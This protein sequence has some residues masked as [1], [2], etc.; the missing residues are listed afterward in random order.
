MCFKDRKIFTYLK[1]RNKDNLEEGKELIQVF[2]SSF[3]YREKKRLRNDF[4][5]TLVPTLLSFS[6]AGIYAI[7]DGFFVGNSL[8]DKGLAAINFAYPFLAL[9]QAL[10]TG[11]GLACAVYYVD[12]KARNKYQ[13]A[14][15]CVFLLLILNLLFALFYLLVAYPHQIFILKLFGASF[16][17]LNLA[18]SYVRIILLGGIFQLLANSLL[19]L[20]RAEGRNF[21][22]AFSMI[23]GFV[24]NL[25]LDYHY[26]FQLKRGIAGAALASV[27]AQA[28]SFLACVFGTLLYKLYSKFSLSPFL[29]VVLLKKR[30]SNVGFCINSK[31]K[32]FY[33]Q[34]SFYQN[35]PYLKMSMGIVSLAFAPIGIELSPNLLLILSN[36]QAEMFG[37]TEAVAAYTII[38]YM[39]F[40]ILLMLQAVCSASQSHLSYYFS[41]KEN[42]HLKQIKK[43]MHLSANFIVLSLLL[44]FV[45][46]MKTLARLYGSSPK[47]E[48]LL[49]QALP[50]F[51]SGLI[52][53]LYLRTQSTYAYSIQNRLEANFI[54]YG[55]IF[56]AFIALLVLPIFLGLQGVWLAPLLAQILIFS[57]Y[58]I[59]Y[60]KPKFFFSR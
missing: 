56:F 20:L 6:L 33:H 15:M 5:R 4:L 48:S 43:W 55:E 58:L 35:F 42:L 1:S 14:R 39:T 45:S 32:I 16:E 19:P 2:S 53:L 22:A 26:V 24:V 17:V 52:I 25:Y 21:L 10:G 34:L 8:G 11:L 13:E 51:I 49:F 23:L 7:V 36:K 60:I 47:A 28:L 27:T 31:R 30:L 59:F 57:L 29:Q 54:I 44:L 18:Q 3:S 9:F 38:A 40:I 50:Y 41:K 12:Y 46:Q 37:G